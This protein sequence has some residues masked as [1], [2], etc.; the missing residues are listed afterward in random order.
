[1]VELVTKNPIAEQVFGAIRAA[2][3]DWD[4]KDPVRRLG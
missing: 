4:G 3:V 2:A 1:M